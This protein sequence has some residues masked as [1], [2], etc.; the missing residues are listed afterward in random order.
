MTVLTVLLHACVG[1]VCPADERVDHFE[2]TI[3]PVLSAHCFSC[4]ST[5]ANAKGVLKGQLRLDSGPGLFAGGASGPVVLPGKPESSLLI[6]AIKHQSLEMPPNKTLTENVIQDFEQWVRDGAIYPEH[7][8]KS[9]DAAH[10]SLLPVIAPA[11]PV[12]PDDEWS[13]T[14]IDRFIVDQLRDKSL[15][16]G[17]DASKQRLLR[18]VTFDLTGLPPT[19]DDIHQFLDDQSPDAWESLIDRLLNSQHYGERWARHWLDVAR[20]ADTTANDGN[21]VMRYAYRYR[22]Y[23]IQAFNQDLPFD[24]FIIEQIAGDLMAPESPKLDL[25]RRIAT[26]FLMLGPKGLAETDKEQLRLDMADEQIDVTTRAFL[27]MSFSCARCHDHKFDPI[28]TKDY[29]SLAG[30]FRGI[31]MLNGQSGPTSMW[32]ETSVEYT[33]LESKR[34][35]E[36]LTADLTARQN[37]LDAI[38][39][40]VDEEQ[41]AWEQTLP[42]HRDQTGSPSRELSPSLLDGLLAWYSADSLNTDGKILLWKNRAEWDGSD[43]LDLTGTAAVAPSL[44]AD[45]IGTRPAVRF[46]ENTHML[47][48]KS[49]LDISG[50]QA[51]TFVVVL[52]PMASVS[53]RT[54]AVSFGDPT[55]PHAGVIFEIDKAANPGGRLDL[56]TGHSFDAYAGE[57]EFNAPQIWMA[58]RQGGP[59][60]E[61]HVE[62]SGVRREL[63]S[64]GNAMLKLTLIPER[65][66]IG[67]HNHPSHRSSS[68]PKMDVAELLIFDR[69]IE[70]QQLQHIGHY[71]QSKYRIHGK[72]TGTLKDIVSTPV[73]QRTKESA[74]HLRRR[75]LDS[76]HKTDYLKILEQRNDLRQ[77][78]PQAEAAAQHA[79]VMMPKEQHGIDLAVHIRGNRHTQGEVAERRTPSLF[80]ANNSIRVDTLQSGRLELAKWIANNNNHLTARVIVNR[81]WQW[82]FGTGIV[83]SSDNFGRIGSLPTHPGLLDYL[84]TIFL[85][86]GWSIKKLHKRILLSRVYQQ[87]SVAAKDDVAQALETDPENTLLW[88]FP[89]RRLEAE[90][91]RDSLLA[92]SG[93]LDDSYAGGGELVHELYESGDVIDR[94]LGLVSA[95][96]VYDVR[97]FSVPRRTIYLPVIRNGQNEIIAVFDAA[98]ANAVTTRR[99]E[100]IV[101][102]QA[103]FLL[104][105]R[106]VHRIA[107]EFAGRLL[108]DTTIHSNQERIQKAYRIAVGRDATPLEVDSATQFRTQYELEFLNTTSADSNE[109]MTAKESAES[110]WTAFCHILYCLNEFIYVD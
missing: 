82:H 12:L 22:N 15:S 11:V 77:T 18:R 50:N 83:R 71:L 68:S 25:R 59:L 2:K 88:S 70:D 110:S 57:F 29:Y 8:S 95:A 78:L 76:R 54:H 108:A 52:N 33:S 56:A 55:Q 13:R 7:A 36:Q 9:P 100:S 73:D 72:Y 48:S 51:F 64:A 10:W 61:S 19:E 49:A 6:S 106:Y 35:I 53:K 3:R 60:L 1:G 103:S 46:E 98:D 47:V 67:G 80:P 34:Q 81:I 5:S 42:K 62:I 75:F 102:T 101:A 16:P 4:H 96:N 27:G 69:A 97:A 44:V 30:I 109:T 41:L 20:Y 84:A 66:V 94:T 21:F 38:L 79:D 17:R 58:R 89:R 86:D 65:I 63:E 37:E 24:Q 92:T 45:A 26:G 99:N 91:I 43:S 90:A 28:P 23:V 74:Q 104:N 14:D 32:H 40:V 39:N 85:E 31:E 107:K 105:S 87:D 93:T